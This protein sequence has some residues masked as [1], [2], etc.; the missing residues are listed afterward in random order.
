MCETLD[1]IYKRR[2]VR[3]YKPEPVSDEDLHKI[4]K[5][6]QLAPTGW[7]KQPWHFIVVKDPKLKE[8]LSQWK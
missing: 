5:A 1:V 4:M 6:G 8:Q 2:S 7:N 3:K